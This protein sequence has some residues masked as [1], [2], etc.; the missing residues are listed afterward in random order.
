MGGT[1]LAANLFRITQTAE[2]L[3]REKTGLAFNTISAVYLRHVLDYAVYP[4]QFINSNPAVDSVSYKNARRQIGNE[5]QFGAG[6]ICIYREDN[7][8]KV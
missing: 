4:A 5:K 8:Q 7:A 3:R 2:K 1:E 6:Y